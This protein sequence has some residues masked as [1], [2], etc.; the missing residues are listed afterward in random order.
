MLGLEVLQNSPYPLQEAKMQTQKARNELSGLKES[1]TVKLRD[2]EESREIYVVLYEE[3]NKR[4]VKAQKEIMELKQR[5]ED[6]ERG[7]SDR[8][9]R[10]YIDNVL[11]Q[12]YTFALYPLS[13]NEIIFVLSFLQGYHSPPG[14]S[15][16]ATTTTTTRTTLFHVR[17]SRTLSALR[18][19]RR[20]GLFFLGKKEDVSF[21][22]RSGAGGRPI[23]EQEEQEELSSCLRNTLPGGLGSFNQPC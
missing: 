4:L 10:Y 8:I 16:A 6:M 21:L 5:I 3:E 12:L 2:A 11:E 7:H 20:R 14:R 22:P 18:T 19:G 9:R 17:R 23:Q 15:Y 1:H 13:K